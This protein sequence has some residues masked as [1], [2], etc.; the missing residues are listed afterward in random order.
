LV[1]EHQPEVR[2]LFVDFKR[3]C[4]Y[5]EKNSCQVLKNARLSLF[6]LEKQKSLRSQN[7][8]DGFLRDDYK[9]LCEL[10]LLEKNLLTH[11]E[12]VPGKLLK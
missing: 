11:T 10:C 12:R 8:D 4:Y 3:T 7:Q 1:R 9:E 5:L 2:T 6:L